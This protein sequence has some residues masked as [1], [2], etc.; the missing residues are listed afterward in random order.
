MLVRAFLAMM[1]LMFAAFGL[2]SLLEPVAMAASLGVEVAGPNGAYE[3]RGIYGG[4]S[5]GAAALCAAGSLRE[6]MR[7]PALWF[8]V[9]Y[10]G[11]YVFAR[12]AALL[13]GPG[14]TPGF[15]PFVAFESV[16][17]LLAILALS[18]GRKAATS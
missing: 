5:L 6:A 12:A 11:G 4:V 16:C 2:W 15:W 3:L 17:A 13:L 18:A 8:L 9:A 10:M 14:P 1:A 7:R